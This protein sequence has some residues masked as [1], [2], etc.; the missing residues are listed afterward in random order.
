MVKIKI[1]TWKPRLGTVYSPR[2]VELVVGVE[3]DMEDVK[4]AD[5]EGEVREEE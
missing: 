2:V 4:D 1:K 5:D 3:I